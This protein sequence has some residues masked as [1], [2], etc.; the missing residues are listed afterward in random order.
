MVVVASFKGGS[1]KT[2]TATHLAGA[3]V[4]RGCNVLLVD[5]DPQC[6]ATSNYKEDGVDEEKRSN[7]EEAK[8]AQQGTKAEEEEQEPLIPSLPLQPTSSSSATSSSAAQHVVPIL[9][10]QEQGSIPAMNNPNNNPTYVP[11]EANLF[12]E[13]LEPNLYSLLERVNNPQIGFDVDNL[14]WV[15]MPDCI[16]DGDDLPPC[17][18]RLFL[19]PSDQRLLECERELMTAQ[20]VPGKR[21]NW[22]FFRWAVQ[23]IAARAQCTFVIVDVN[24]SASMF[25]GMIAMSCDAM[26]IPSFADNFARQALYGLLHVVLPL[27]CTYQVERWQEE[28]HDMDGQA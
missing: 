16:N 28:K 19:L 9:S 11:V 4:A 13:T 27:W 12:T 22:G 6:N 7:D 21:R 18:G 26:I 5:A 24:P 15:P 17:M 20:T 3:L 10:A 2:T 8:Q 1:G 14:S 25:Y 23:R